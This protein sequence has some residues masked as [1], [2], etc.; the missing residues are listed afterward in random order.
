MHNSTS[1]G[2]PASDIRLIANQRILIPGAGGWI[3]SVRTKAP[4]KFGMEAAH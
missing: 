3:E 1:G 2:L 4:K